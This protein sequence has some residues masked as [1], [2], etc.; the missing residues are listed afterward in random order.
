MGHLTRRCE[1]EQIIETKSYK[2]KE[3]RQNSHALLTFP[4]NVHSVIRPYLKEHLLATASIVAAA[5]GRLLGHGAAVG[6]EQDLNG[7][8]QAKVQRHDNDKQ[9]LARLAVRGAEDRVEIA[10][11]KGAGD[12]ET[13]GDERPVENGDGGPADARDGDP[14]EV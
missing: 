5:L 6:K 2:A 4:F 12:A 1:S 9:H 13:D 3:L 11:E 10:Q 8:R 14:D 7:E